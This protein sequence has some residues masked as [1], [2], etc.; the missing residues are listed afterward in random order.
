[1]TLVGP[2]Q[3]PRT[4]AGCAGSE[5]SWSREFAV[6]VFQGLQRLWL[7]ELWARF[8]RG[9]EALRKCGELRAFQ[10]TF[11]HSAFLLRLAHG[12][13]TAFVLVE[14]ESCGLGIYS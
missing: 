12:L 13:S 8:V 6:E 9:H 11:S 2:F 14:F 7:C 5:Q 3:L 1:M 10:G 4:G